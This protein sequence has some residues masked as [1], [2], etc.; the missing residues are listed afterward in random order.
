MT[1]SWSRSTRE[2]KMSLIVRFTASPPETNLTG[3]Q[4]QTNAKLQRGEGLRAGAAGSITFHDV[5]AKPKLRCY[6]QP[7]GVTAAVQHVGEK[8]EAGQVGC[9][10]KAEVGM[11][12]P[13]S[14]P[15]EAPKNRVVSGR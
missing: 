13:G 14:S 2:K 4:A 1:R 11:N 9:D 10:A 15:S 5:P 7:H 6:R 3:S 12:L 8:V